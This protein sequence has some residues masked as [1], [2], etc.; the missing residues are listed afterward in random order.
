MA[1]DMRLT[2]A[3]DM[4]E[5]C[6]GVQRTSLTHLWIFSECTSQLTCARSHTQGLCISVIPQRRITDT[7]GKVEVVGVLTTNQ[8]QLRAS[9]EMRF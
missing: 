8:S 4:A 2:A 7:E 3:G 9:S 5:Q 6:G 1:S